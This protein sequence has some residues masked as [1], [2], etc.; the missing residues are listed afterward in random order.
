MRML[1]LAIYHGPK[2]LRHLSLPPSDVKIIEEMSPDQ[3]DGTT[4]T[5]TQ[6]LS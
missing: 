5:Y 2:I 3:L 4:N 1:H 6:F